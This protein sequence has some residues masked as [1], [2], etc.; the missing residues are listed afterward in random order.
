MKRF[1]L[2]VSMALLVFLAIFMVSCATGTQTTKQTAL[3]F[4]DQYNAAYDSTLSM[5]TNPAATPAQKDMVVKKKAILKQM[6]PAL[7]TYTSIVNSGGTPSAS[8]SKAIQD[9]VDQ[10]ATLAIG[11]K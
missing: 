4:L 8:D 9:F 6:W 3:Y 10:L 1:K 11:G 2:Q 7:K 5:A